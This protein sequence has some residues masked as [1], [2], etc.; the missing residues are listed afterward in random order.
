VVGVGMSDARWSNHVQEQQI[1]DVH[2]RMAELP[3]PDEDLATFESRMRQQVRRVV[4]TPLTGKKH[5]LIEELLQRDERPRGYGLGVWPRF[6]SRID[7]LR[8]RLL[9]TFFFACERYDGRPEIRDE[10]AYEVAIRVGGTSVPVRLAP[11]QRSDDPLRLSLLVTRPHR[12]GP[13]FGAWNE[14]R[15]KLDGQLTEVVV[16]VLVAA[17]VL[18]REAAVAAH[19]AELAR[20]AEEAEDE[21]RRRAQAERARVERLVEEAE[22]HRRAEDVRAFVAAARAARVVPPTGQGHSLGEWAAWAL[23]AADRIDPLVQHRSGPESP[24]RQLR[25]TG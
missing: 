12:T 9:N 7:R 6:Y 24:A 20:Q 18:R 25:R 17:E 10:R 8:L 23:A 16:M 2:R 3:V 14:R 21:R 1:E 22:G 15:T 13:D 11:T 4:V 19:K 5:P